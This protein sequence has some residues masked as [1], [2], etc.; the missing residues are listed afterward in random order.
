M[1]TAFQC[2]QFRVQHHDCAMKVGTDSLL[3]G[4]WC[5]VP[6]R[7]LCLDIG[8][9]CGLLALMV[10]QRTAGSNVRIDA[11]ELDAMA[12]LQAHS[13]VAASPWPTRVRV[14]ERDILTYLGSA[15]HASA[16]KA[17]GYQ[18][19]ISNPPY[20]E[21]SLPSRDAK[22]QQARHTDSLPFEQLL[23]VAAQL[24][25][26][27]AQLALVLPTPA[28]Q[29]IRQ[30]AGTYGWSLQQWQP[31]QMTPSKPASRVLLLLS[32]DASGQATELPALCVRGDDAEYTADYRRLLKDFYLRF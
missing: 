13:N 27:A 25:A 32:R 5:P 2:K 16:A 31:V 28:A 7:G 11:V 8:T 12:A 23:H 21:Q 10:A 22:R 30:L 9:G 3:L 24:A 1:Q 4:A 17:G 26:P 14:L 20:F 19:I 29:R 6:T 18:L 15:D